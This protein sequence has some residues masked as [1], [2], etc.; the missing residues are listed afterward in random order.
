MSRLKDFYYDEIV[1][2][3][4]KKFGYTNKM[5]V[6]K[7]DKIVLNMGIGGNCMLGGGLGPIGRIRYTADLLEGMLTKPSLSP[8]W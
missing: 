6:P 8:F 4:I 1:D 7:L 5:Q 3:L 2:A